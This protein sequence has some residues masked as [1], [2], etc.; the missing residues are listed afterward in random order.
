MI[1]K[2]LKTRLTHLSFRIRRMRR[3][4]DAEYR[5]EAYA[6]CLLLEA[7]LHDK[8]AEAS[9]VTVEAPP[10]VATTPILRAPSR[11]ISGTET[12]ANSHLGRIFQRG[13][14]WNDGEPVLGTGRGTVGSAKRN[15]Q[16]P[17]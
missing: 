5:N 6:T 12:S 4:R 10:V 11:E 8:A 15:Q 13:G 7:D 14:K 2:R 3:E 9:P 17:F 16:G 1:F